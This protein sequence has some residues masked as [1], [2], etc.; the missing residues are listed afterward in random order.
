MT[1]IAEATRG[2]ADPRVQKLIAWIR[3]KLLTDG[4]WNDR[5]V[6]I[7]TEYTDTNRYLEQQLRARPRRLATRLTGIDPL[8]LRPVLP[9]TLAHLDGCGLVIDSD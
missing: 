9:Q 1:E 5:R 4:R 7:F 3:E 2:V 6:L 8:H